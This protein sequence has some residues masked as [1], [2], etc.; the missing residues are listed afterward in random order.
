MHENAFFKPQRT[1]INRV[2]IVSPE[3]TITEYNTGK[4]TQW[5]Y[6]IISSTV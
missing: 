6:S 4:R 3:C 2:T 1:I 5:K